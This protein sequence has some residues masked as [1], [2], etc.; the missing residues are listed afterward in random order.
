MNAREKL[1]GI[2]EHIPGPDSSP[3]SEDYHNFLKMTKE[4]CEILATHELV[5]IDDAIGLRRECLA[6]I[7]E[8]ERRAKDNS[9]GDAAYRNAIQRLKLFLRDGKT[10]F[11]EEHDET[12]FD[13]ER[14]GFKATHGS[15]NGGIFAWGKR[16]KNVDLALF[17]SDGFSLHMNYDNP[18]L[19]LPP[20]GGSEY[21]EENVEA[22][23]AA[24]IPQKRMV[25]PFWPSHSLALQILKEAGLEVQ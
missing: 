6:L 5:P 25:F 1:Q 15:S 4:A 20:L 21:S 18:R 8:A 22:L 23:K 24:H 2:L 14:C 16:V 11:H 13:P 3:T 17:K 12:P 9:M 19:Y 10:T 7:E